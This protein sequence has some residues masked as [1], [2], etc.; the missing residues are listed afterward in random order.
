MINMID[1]FGLRD[2]GNVDVGIEIE[3]EGEGIPIGED[4]P[5]FWRDLHDGSLRGESREYVLQKPIKLDK[6]DIALESL[7]K[8]FEQVGARVNDSDNCGVHIHVNC[9]RMDTKQVLKF[10]CLYLI[11]EEILVSMC[12]KNRAGNL[13][14]LRARD[15]EAQVFHLCEAKRT[16][17]INGLQGD[18]FRYSS[19]NLASLSKFGTI[20]FRAMRTPQDFRTLSEWIH[21]LVTVRD[22][23]Q[24]FDDI[25][26]MVES[27]SRE[28]AM[29]FLEMV[30]GTSG[31]SLMIP[32]ADDMLMRGVRLVQEIAYTPTIKEYE[33][34]EEEYM[35]VP[36]VRRAFG[37]V[38]HNR[39]VLDQARE[40]PLP[41][42][43]E[44][45][46]LDD[47]DMEDL[48]NEEDEW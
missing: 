15:A 46:V 3:V 45:D 5:M 23:S 18:M 34:R 30:F 6:V 47:L 12:G 26:D 31:R 9:Q 24:K 13:F 19:M 33:E 21:I 7:M 10:A 25:K 4:I 14:C 37:I 17:S 40:I 32:D 20:E 41:E 36:R 44:D 16:L 8:S 35:G 27:V 48:E 43:H 1:K 2:A 29:R 39:I 28:G 22:A 38:D 42:D 11:L